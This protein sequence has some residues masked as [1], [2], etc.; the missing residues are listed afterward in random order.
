MD[1]V[2]L[3]DKSQQNGMEKLS[4]E[5]E[6]DLSNLSL[7]ES[8]D[9]SNGNPSPMV[10]LDIF[11]ITARTK[12]KITTE[13]AEKGV[14]DEPYSPRLSDVGGLEKQIQL[15]SDLVMHPLEKDSKIRGGGK[16][17]LHVANLKSPFQMLCIHVESFCMVLLVSASL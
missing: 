15:L 11:K 6:E 4:R 14:S 7:N 9:F 16:F 5:L 10:D 13:L 1:I 17:F 12:F 2:P 3:S 8:G